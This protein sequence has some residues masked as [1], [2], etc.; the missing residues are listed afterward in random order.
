MNMKQL[1]KYKASITYFEVVKKK[2]ITHIYH[3]LEN[4]NYQKMKIHKAGPK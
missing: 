4:L 1:E 3:P 2:S